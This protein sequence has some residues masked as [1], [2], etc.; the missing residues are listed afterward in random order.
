M[1]SSLLQNSYPSLKFQLKSH[2]CQETYQILLPL[3]II[4]L[5][6]APYFFKTSHKRSKS[7]LYNKHVFTHVYLSVCVCA[8]VFK[9]GTKG[10]SEEQE[11]QEGEKRKESRPLLGKK[12][13]AAR[14]PIG[15]PHRLE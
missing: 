13:G 12:K 6:I 8:P 14:T 3:T 10:R 4:S 5:P 2:L 1:P 11:G 7:V 9:E 15:S